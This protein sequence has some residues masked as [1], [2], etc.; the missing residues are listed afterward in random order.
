MRL[1]A[2]EGIRHFYFMMLQKDE[3][4][5]GSESCV[6]LYLPVKHSLLMPPNVAELV[7]SP[8]IVVTRTVMSL[9]GRLAIMFVWVSLRTGTSSNTKS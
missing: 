5:N 4:C 9:N 8:T 3:V 2:E 7:V 1:Y 6:S